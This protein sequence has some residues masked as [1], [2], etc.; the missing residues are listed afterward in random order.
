MKNLYLKCPRCREHFPTAYIYCPF[1]NGI[2]LVV[3]D[4][5]DMFK[6]DFNDSDRVGEILKMVQLIWSK[7]K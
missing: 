7:V 1:C 3:N 2:E 5:E 4:E 6:V